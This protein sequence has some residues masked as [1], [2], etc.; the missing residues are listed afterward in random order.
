MDSCLWSGQ[1]KSRLGLAL[2]VPIGLILGVFPAAA[3]EKKLPSAEWVLDKSIEA[4][5][6]KEALKKLTC[7][8]SKGTVEF[9]GGPGPATK[10]TVTLYEAAPNKR[11]YVVQ[12]PQLTR[13]VGTD[14]EVYWELDHAQNP[15]LREGE[16]KAVAERQAD[17]Y[18]A[19]HWRQHY[20]KVECVG[21]E[22]VEGRSCYKLVLTPK[23]G[24]P[25]T[26]YYERKTGLPIKH[27][28]VRKTELGD[29][30]IEILLED[31]REVDGIR[32]PFKMVRRFS[33]MGQPQTA[34]TVWES[35]Q[36][37]VE[38]P[39]EKF[40]LPGPVKAL[41]EKTKSAP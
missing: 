35:I 7:R 4:L 29:T 24:P 27:E 6:G 12:L 11:R 39:P 32:L 37:N 23:I 14:G 34:V 2:L 5:G 26:V 33:T 16:E 1:S 25:E 41:L 10:G 13:E 20:E 22:D 17:F 3:Q 30:P 19:L 21:D 31:Y 15:R 38:I 40:E 9:T 36:H 8:V 28:I 18:A